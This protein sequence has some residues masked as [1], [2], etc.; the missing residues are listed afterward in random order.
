MFAARQS[1][2]QPPLQAHSERKPAMEG[3]NYRNAG[4]VK[5][6]AV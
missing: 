4:V 5:V 2:I 1:R 6:V 3:L